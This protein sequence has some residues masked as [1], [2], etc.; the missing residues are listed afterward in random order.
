[1]SIAGEIFARA[2]EQPEPRR[3]AFV[4]RCTS[5]DDTLRRDVEELLRTHSKM[6]RFMEGASFEPEPELDPDAVPGHELVRKVGEGGF[7]TV[8]LAR[9]LGTLDRE[10]AIKVLKDELLDDAALARFD[11]ER[12][13]LANL[14]HD[15]I[16]RI[17]T[18]GT[19]VSRTPYYSMEFVAG[20]SI[21]RHADEHRLTLEE[22]IEL[23]LPVCRAVA[24]AHQRGVIHGDLKPK[25]VL[26]CTADEDPSPKVI[27]FGVARSLGDASTDVLVAGTPPYMS[28]EQRQGIAADTRSDIYSL[29]MVLR[30]LLIGRHGPGDAA[31]D[32][33]FEGMDPE[34]RNRLTQSRCTSSRALARALRG[35]IAH[36]VDVATHVDPEDRFGTVR[37]LIADLECLLRNRALPSRPQR[38]FYLL[39]K[40]VSRHWF[41]LSAALLLAALGTLFGLRSWRYQGIAERTET[42]RQDAE[43]RAKSW[44]EAAAATLEF[45]DDVFLSAGPAER[46]P[47]VTLLTVVDDAQRRFD[48]APPSVPLVVAL[49]A[50]TMGRLRS[51]LDQQEAAE[52]LFRRS[53]A[54]LD[55]CGPKHRR[56]RAIAQLELAEKI[57]ERNANDE[58]RGLLQQALA[59]FT[60][61]GDTVRLLLAMRLL[62]IAKVHD[63]FPRDALEQLREAHALSVAELGVEHRRTRELEV[64]LADLEQQFGDPAA[65]RRLGATNAVANSQNLGFY[66]RL[67]AKITEAHARFAA[68][69][70]DDAETLAREVLRIVG[71]RGMPPHTGCATQATQLLGSVAQRRGKHRLALKHFGELFQLHHAKSGLKARRTQQ[72][73]RNVLAMLVN[74]RRDEQALAFLEKYLP[75]QADLGRASLHDITIL[76]SR[77]MLL[78]RAGR[79]VETPRIHEAIVAGATK[80]F[81][82]QHPK[83]MRYRRRFGVALSKAERHEDALRVVSDLRKGCED[84][85]GAAHVETFK[86]LCTLA[87]VLGA[88]GR[89]DDGYDLLQKALSRALEAHGPAHIVIRYVSNA[90]RSF[91]SQHDRA[92]VV[93]RGRAQIRRSFE[94]RFEAGDQSEELRSAWS[95]FRKS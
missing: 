68:A 78:E 14:Q 26:V 84:R 39:H 22:R 28:P 74:L 1:M 76:A 59:T 77:A 60:E 30:E 36:V 43:T 41:A 6:G 72:A 75:E 12:R 65:A 64:V 91:A 15:A 80:H 82:L 40:F 38:P 81:G 32:V 61:T 34:Q 44:G 54:A 63:G 71:E 37:E 46:G 21:D 62:A 88:S 17:F 45:F 5:R 83:T 47:D 69:K 13:V 94:E 95:V 7:G 93:D 87:H 25:N 92:D 18:A 70:Y 66:A 23:F 3:E 52:A 67:R 55:E 2:L 53:L 9:E 8:Y 73:A 56:V 50:R 31:V 48:E 24:H 11:F 10:V 86:A 85:F 33:A 4:Q 58:S 20:L 51:R 42:A 49:L 19:I 79:V 57:A 27:D 89:V 90:Y 29:G 16:A 35:D